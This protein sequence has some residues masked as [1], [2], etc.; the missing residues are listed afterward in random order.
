MAFRR[1]EDDG[2]AVSST[3]SGNSLGATASTELDDYE[4]VAFV[5]EPTG[6]LLCRIHSGIMKDPV[7]AKCGVRISEDFREFLKILKRTSSE[8]WT[9]VSENCDQMCLRIRF[10]GYIR[11]V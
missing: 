11:W 8:N 2:M 4:S 9:C 1:E 5:I 10:C 6:P 3:M 7:I